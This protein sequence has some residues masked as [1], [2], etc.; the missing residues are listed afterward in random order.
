MNKRKA[1]PIAKADT[2]LLAYRTF[3]GLVLLVSLLALNYDT[4]SQFFAFDMRDLTASA[5]MVIK[6]EGV[7][8][9][10]LQGEEEQKFLASFGLTAKDVESLRQSHE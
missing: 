5:S 4:V 10:K 6:P 7:N 1:L 3:L 2:V 8:S 9:E